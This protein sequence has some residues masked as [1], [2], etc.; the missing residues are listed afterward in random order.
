MLGVFNIGGWG[1][2]ILGERIKGC[3]GIITGI[4]LDCYYVFGSPVNEEFE[5]PK[6]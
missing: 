2:L 4:C 3:M 6:P 1:G 5:N